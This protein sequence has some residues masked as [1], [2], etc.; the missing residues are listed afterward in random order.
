MAVYS[1]YNKSNWPYIYR[2][3]LT[4]YACENPKN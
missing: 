4:F 2:S 1:N 3:W